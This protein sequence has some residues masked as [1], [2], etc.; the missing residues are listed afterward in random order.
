MVISQPVCTDNTIKYLHTDLTVF[1]K[2]KRWNETPVR[3]LIPV[4]LPFYI[5]FKGRYSLP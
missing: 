3:G 4:F 5:E 1:I 2:K